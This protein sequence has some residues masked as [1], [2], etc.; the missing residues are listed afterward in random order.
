MLDKSEFGCRKDGEI[1]LTV[2]IGSLMEQ[3]EGW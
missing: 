1:G 2:M 3:K